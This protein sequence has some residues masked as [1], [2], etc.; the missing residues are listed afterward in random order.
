MLK[1]NFDLV[2]E[3]EKNLNPRFPEKNTVPAKV[4]GFG[5]ISTVLEIGEKD[6]DKQFAY[7]RMPLFRNIEEINE[8]E[9]IF[10][11]YHQLLA[12]IGITAPSYQ[13]LHFVENDRFIFYGIQ[14]KVDYNTVCNRLLT[15][16][17]DKEIHILVL[18]I[19][20]NLKKVFEFN[21]INRGRVEIGIDS[22]ISNW[23]L[24]GFKLEESVVTEG[25][26]LIYFDTNTPLIKKNGKEQLNPE[27]FLRSA[28]SFLVWVIRKL[29]LKDIMERYYDIRLVIIDI[30]ANFYKEQRADIIPSVL[31]T[32]NDYID[33]ELQDFK[34]KTITLKEVE[35]YYRE[36]AFIW[37]FYLGAR[38]LDRALHQLLRKNYPYILPDKI[39]R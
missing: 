27:L 22:Q 34:I 10:S 31:D 15:Y 38:K 9:S 35:S 4:L 7:K 18:L 19:L 8:Y 5:E 39:K 12:E 26:E 16:I 37:R 13:T 30:L 17:S 3:F 2:K 36:D 11:E 6:E 32:V 20:K 33:S 28:P 1:V 14:E 25:M 24:K 29:F 23:A 21:R